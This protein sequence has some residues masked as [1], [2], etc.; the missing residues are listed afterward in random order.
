V[1]IESKEEKNLKLLLQLANSITSSVYVI[2]SEQRMQIHLAAVIA[3]NFTNHLYSIAEKI[4]NEHDLS[5]DLLRPIIQTAAKNIGHY[6]PAILQTGPAV[7]GDKKILKKH[8]E[9]LKDHPEWK[10]IYKLIT[11]SIGKKI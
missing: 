6:S 8:L 10:K 9:L 3:N 5:F 7:R 2:N 11:E 1:C 4:L